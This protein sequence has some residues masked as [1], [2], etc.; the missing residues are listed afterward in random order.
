MNKLKSGYTTGT[1]AAAAVAAAAHYL[2]TREEKDVVQ[3]TLPTQ[4]KRYIDV[5]PVSKGD[6][7]ACYAV[8]KDSGDDPDITNGCM[9]QANVQ[10]LNEDGAVGFCAGVGVGM[11]TLDGLKIS[12]GE[13]AINPVP[14]QMMEKEF[15]SLYKKRAAMITVSIPNGE[16]LAKR[17]M[18]ARLGV[19]GGLSIL[20]TTGIVRPMSVEALVDTIKTEMDVRMAQKKDLVLT[21]GAMGEEALIRLGYAPEQMVQISNYV[22][23][24]L[25]YA[26]EQGIS[27]VILAGH[28]GKMIKVAGGIF[29][30]HSKW[31]DA[32]MEIVCAHAALVGVEDD[33]MKEIFACATISAADHILR[34]SPL[35]DRVW[36]QIADAVPQKIAQRWAIRTKAIVLDEYGE[37]CAISRE[38]K[39]S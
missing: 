13:A 26:A 18:N 23:E 11:V 12:A 28:A 8:I 6:G 24:A 21:F 39:N 31:A 35:R 1:C 33:K 10:L 25:D 22:G 2:Y 27:N 29:Q 15:R 37:I 16:Q 17:T 7:E 36:Q 34:E 20:G 19:V 14:R 32:R 38:E 9:V 4:E 30:T 5:Y 3:I